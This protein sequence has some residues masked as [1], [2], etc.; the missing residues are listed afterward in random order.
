[1]R[2]QAQKDGRPVVCEILRRLIDE[3]KS[4]GMIA[5]SSLEEVIT[6]G[7]VEGRTNFRNISYAGIGVRI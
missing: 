6:G 4:V 5:R 1:M 3:E 2:R 7:L